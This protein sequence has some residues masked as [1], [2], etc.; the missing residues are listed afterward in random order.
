[1]LN[2]NMQGHNENI[3]TTTDNVTGFLKKLQLWLRRAVQQYIEMFLSVKR[4]K[5]SKKLYAFL[6][7]EIS[8]N[9][10]RKKLITFHRCLQKIQLG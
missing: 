2:A 1:M 8:C 3:L 10:F 4:N 7:T 5:T 9:T 6:Y